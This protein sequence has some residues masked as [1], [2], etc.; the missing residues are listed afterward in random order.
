M[1][2]FIAGEK[3]MI[4]FYILELL[5]RNFMYSSNIAPSME[6]PFTLLFLINVMDAI[7]VMYGKFLEID[8]HDFPNKRD[9][10]KL[11]NIFDRNLKDILIKWY[12]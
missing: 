10:R 3:N 1:K 5:F 4:L 12:F 2:C 6:T 11:W 9:G 8:K 7:S